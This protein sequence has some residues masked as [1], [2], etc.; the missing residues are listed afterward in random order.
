MKKKIK[1][2]FASSMEREESNELDAFIYDLSDKF[3]RQY[4]VRIRPV[5][6]DDMRMEEELRSCEMAFFVFFQ[7]LGEHTRKQFEE[8]KTFFEKSGV[9]RI[10][11]YFK[12]VTEEEKE[13][14][15]RQFARELDAVFG[16]YYSSFS[17]LDTVKLRILLGIKLQEMDFVDLSV[18]DGMCKVNGQ[19]VLSVEHLPEFANSGLL[20]ELRK[21]LEKLEETYFQMR[22]IYAKGGADKAFY[23][24]Y[25]DVC[26]RRQKLKDS[27]GEL[28]ETIFNM[29]V[30]IVR[31]V[32][33]GEITQRQKEAYRLF[34][35]GD[36]D[37][38]MAVLDA[39]EINADFWAWEERQKKIGKKKAEIFI[40][41]HKTAIDV[42][43]GMYHYKDRFAEI[44][45]RYGWIMEA[46]MKYRTEAGTLLDYVVFL[47]VQQDYKKAVYVAERTK[48]LFG[49]MD[50]EVD[51]AH[52]IMLYNNLANLYNDTQRQQE[53][54]E[55]YKK[56]MGIRERL[57]G[58]NAEAYEFDLVVSY[59]N[60]A[61][62]YSDTQ[63]QTEAEEMYKKAVGILER[64]AERNA[65]EHES[66]LA[67]GYNNLAV[68]YSVTQRQKEAEEMYKKAVGIQE[69]LA[70]R[71]AEEHEGDLAMSYGNLANLYSDTQRQQE[72]E[73]MCKKAVRIYERLAGRNAEEHE[74]SLVASYNNLANLYRKSQRQQE[75]EKLCKKA[76]EIWERLAER[77]AAAYESNLVAN[78]NNLAILYSDMQRQQEAEEMYKKA[79]EIW[80][81]LAGRN[82]AAYEPRLAVCY[83]NI[84]VLYLEM[85]KAFGRRIYRKKAIKLAKKYPQDYICKQ[86]L[87]KL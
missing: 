72:A 9:P 16:H 42:L 70:E 33:R 30:N 27:I 6:E 69:R 24:E 25:A 29:S 36:Y 45:E 71:N 47:Y 87:D 23:R 86:I 60:L 11:T 28:E 38:C 40:R 20:R 10:Y 64:L 35:L 59:N 74:S 44:R 75:A 14:E 48:E 37:G 3:E 41:E 67:V 80:K 82:A 43:M 79:V 51:D 26:S 85:G 53:A 66:V 52:W 77:N 18:K 54:E 65:E 19:D 2:F 34:E 7:K 61:N 21:E 58:R 78:Y 50:E 15:L 17:H 39:E 49:C 63:R 76:V 22:P 73:E 13:E 55:L 81:R 84:S 32:I 68:L 12:E 83:W 56:A 1:I 62:L 57:A 31:D 8:A 4:D 46:A 5:H